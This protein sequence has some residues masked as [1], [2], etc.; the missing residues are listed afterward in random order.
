MYSSFSLSVFIIMTFNKMK[1]QSEC[2]GN[3]KDWDK[4][5][6]CGAYSDK[7]IPNNMISLYTKYFRHK[8]IL[9]I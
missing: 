9:F 5:I 3:L 4:L 8:V 7:G 1:I 2:S 6:H